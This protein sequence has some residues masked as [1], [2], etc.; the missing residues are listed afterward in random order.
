M[1]AKARGSLLMVLLMSSLLL[2][3][4]VASLSH[5]TAKLAHQTTLPRLLEH[6]TI[7]SDSIHVLTSELCHDFT[8]LYSQDTDIFSVL[9][10]RCHTA[11]IT[12]P[13]DKEE[14]LKMK[15]KDLI[16]LVIYL[17]RSWD[18]P[19]SHLMAQAVHLPEVPLNF[20]E[21][22]QSIQEKIQ[23]LLE[24][25][26][27]MARQLGLQVTDY[28]DY[29]VWTELAPLN[30]DKGKDFTDAFHHLCHCLLRDT[31]KVDSFLKVLK[32]YVSHDR[33][34]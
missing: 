20:M 17:M 1:N 18:D 13:S 9:R 8:T 23:Q 2:W 25:L 33:H 14:I 5:C 31:Y 7:L 16:I 15:E 10:K 28:V 24:G 22:S 26:K 4:N 6:A 29:A 21:K 19:L 27:T 11:S 32:A 30:S 3:K 34:K 12:T